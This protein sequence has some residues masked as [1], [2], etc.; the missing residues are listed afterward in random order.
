MFH[1]IFLYIICLGLVSSDCW[2]EM[3]FG[4]RDIKIKKYTLHI[5]TLFQHFNYFGA[6][7]HIF[8]LKCVLY[9]YIKRDDSGYLFIG[10]VLMCNL[11]TSI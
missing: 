1:L 6:H 2:I 5:S 11:Y 8:T 9:I 4:G 3:R 7:Y 10:Q